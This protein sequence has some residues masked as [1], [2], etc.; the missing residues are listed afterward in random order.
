[1]NPDPDAAW[2]ALAPYLSCQQL[3]D[4]VALLRAR[5]AVRAIDDEHAPDTDPLPGDY[6]QTPP[7]ERSRR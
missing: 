5:D 1:M 4:L 3:A 2:V 7:T 6:Y